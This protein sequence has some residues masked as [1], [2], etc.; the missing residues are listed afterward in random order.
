VIVQELHIA[1]EYTPRLDAI[2]DNFERVKPWRKKWK[3]R[4]FDDYGDLLEGLQND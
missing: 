3:Q 2:Q 4:F 1:D